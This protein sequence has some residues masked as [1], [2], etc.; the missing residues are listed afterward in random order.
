MEELLSAREA[1]QEAKVTTQ[2]INQLINEKVLEARKIGS[3]WVIS[4]PSFD[5]WME[6]RKKQWEEG[7]VG[8]V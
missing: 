1:A 5:A 4:R 2:Y 3:F 7:S 6:K 8:N